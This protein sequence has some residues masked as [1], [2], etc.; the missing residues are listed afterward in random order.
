M[1]EYLAVEV[2]GQVWM[3]NGMPRGPL[4]DLGKEGWELVAVTKQGTSSV[5]YFKRKVKNVVK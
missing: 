4:D 1:W 5:A 3:K 2:L